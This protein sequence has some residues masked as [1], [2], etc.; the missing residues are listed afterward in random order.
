MIGI[1]GLL[2]ITFFKIGLFTFGGGYAM[3]PLIMEEVVGLGWV[4]EV[5]LLD[6]IAV[7]ESTPGPFAINTATFIGMNQAGILGVA[8][9]VL[10]L[11]TPSFVIILM[12]A[13][14]LTRFL[15]YKGVKAA[16]VGLS[17]AVIGLMASAVISIAIT[18]FNINLSGLGTEIF[19]NFLEI[20][21]NLNFLGI[22][23]FIIV[24]VASKIFKLN[25]YKIIILSAIM[26]ILLYT[27]NDFLL[28]G[29]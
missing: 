10:G 2:F 28:A 29:V 27:A 13:K 25:T 17:P 6:Y 4:T 15:E 20:A 23:I 12:I 9:A 3:I 5:E 7:A 24:L 26:G 22:I 11:I 1:L 18:A 19:A 21:K 8:V 16:I 14:F